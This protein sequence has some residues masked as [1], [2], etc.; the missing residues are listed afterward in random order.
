MDFELPEDE[1]SPERD[2]KHI[3]SACMLSQKKEEDE[4]QEGF[5]SFV[6]SPGRS[7]LASPRPER[8]ISHI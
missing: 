4:Y 2:L 6:D 8:D 1:P 7:P 3:E 5:E